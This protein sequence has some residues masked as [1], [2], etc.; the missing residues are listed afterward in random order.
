M[1][2]GKVVPVLGADV[3]VLGEELAARF[4][5]AEQDRSLTRVAQFVALTKGSGPRWLA[6]WTIMIARPGTGS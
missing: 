4:G 3:G 2:A 1:L 6:S 5:F